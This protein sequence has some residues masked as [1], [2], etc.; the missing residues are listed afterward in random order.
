MHHID[1]LALEDSPGAPTYE[2]EDEEYLEFEGEYQGEEEYEGQDGEAFEGEDEANSEY[3]DAEEVAET[4]EL[5]LATE[6]LEVQNEQHLDRFIG[7]L[8]RS[9][10]AAVHDFARTR[11]GRQLGG[12]LKQA[13][14]R[15]L[16]VL[17]RAAG[18]AVGGAVAR[19][20]GRSVA[21][22]RRAGG[23][24]GASLGTLARRSFGLELESISAEDQEF[25]VARRFVRFGQEA[26][27]DC[28]QRLGTGPARQVARQAAVTAGRRHAPGLLTD[29]MLD[30]AALARSAVSALPAATAPTPATGRAV[31][32][33][34]APARAGAAQS[35]R[36]PRCGT[37]A[38]TARGGRWERRGDAIVLFNH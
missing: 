22:G 2:Q 32:Q 26:V 7:D 9:A 6:F 34:A 21:S 25:E 18:K 37:A 5:E 16:P 24:A 11:E 36:C 10:S 28:V 3:E 8:M 13:A 31:A 30:A 14:G 29:Q 17:G 20:T 15:V 1:Q 33:P 12:I 23:R 38:V 35:R 4:A 27:R 19:A